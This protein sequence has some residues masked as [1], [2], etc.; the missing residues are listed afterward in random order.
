MKVEPIYVVLNKQAVF[1]F[2][3]Y[4][5]GKQSSIYKTKAKSRVARYEREVKHV[6]AIRKMKYS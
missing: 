4:L 6:N 1:M 2:R 3:K 5:Q